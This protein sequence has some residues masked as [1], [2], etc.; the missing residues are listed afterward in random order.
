MGIKEFAQLINFKR[1]PNKEVNAHALLFDMNCMIYW[2]MEKL[3][4]SD[5]GKG[6]MEGDSIKLWTDT[7]D[8]VTVLYET[9]VDIMVKCITENKDAVSVFLAF[10]GVPAMMKMVE[11]RR[12]RFAGRTRVVNTTN[13]EL[14]NSTTM[15]PSSLFMLD[16]YNHVTENLPR[17]VK[18]KIEHSGPEDPGEGEYKLMV[19]LKNLV[20]NNK[21]EKAFNAFVYSNDNDINVLNLLF[22]AQ[23]SRGIGFSPVN[24]TMV[25]SKA[26]IPVSVIREM[27]LSTIPGSG[28]ETDKVNTFLYL[29]M[30][31]GN[32][33]L[34]RISKTSTKDTYKILCSCLEEGKLFF[35]PASRDGMADVKM[36]WDVVSS[37]LKRAAYKIKNNVYNDDK[38]I[39]LTNHN[40]LANDAQTMKCALTAASVQFLSMTKTICDIYL[41]ITQIGLRKMTY[42]YIYTPYN[43]YDFG[44]YAPGTN[45]LGIMADFIHRDTESQHVHIR[46]AVKASTFRPDV[47]DSVSFLSTTYFEHAMSPYVQASFVIPYV[48]QNPITVPNISSNI[49]K[50]SNSLSKMILFNPSE[51]CLP[52]NVHSPAPLMLLKKYTGGPSN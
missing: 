18:V 36:N 23:F 12:R 3:N 52:Y 37:F 42:N 27:V 2:A 31:L 13:Q 26:N 11:Q 19:Y 24:L 21:T 49:A 51:A 25:N 33:F 30:F 34:P 44:M 8:F 10:D 22:Y 38:T 7:K 41:S 20:T 6:D 50:S 40:F 14:F 17:L 28:S 48:L 15:V 5:N 1:L 9:L 32:D 39:G 43:V 47:A 29:T 45:I 46:K 16:C 4:L 35:E